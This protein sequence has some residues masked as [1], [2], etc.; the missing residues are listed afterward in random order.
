MR[1]LRRK[2]T[3][4]M[5]SMKQLILTMKTTTI[6]TIPSPPSNKAW[7]NYPSKKNNISSP[8]RPSPTFYPRPPSEW[9]DCWV[10]PTRGSCMGC[11]RNGGHGRIR[12]LVWIMLRKIPKRQRMR[13]WRMSNNCRHIKQVDFLQQRLRIVVPNGR[14][15]G[16]LRILNGVPVIRSGCWQVTIML[17]SIIH[18]PPPTQQE[19]WQQEI[20]HPTNN[21]L[22]HSPPPLPPPPH[23]HTITKES[24]QS[25]I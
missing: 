1:K 11:S 13:M 14:M 3:T 25:T 9:N 21:S 6:L 5:T 22:L 12:I 7:S 4:A 19:Q 2:R 10:H 18:L 20:C 8:R 17:Y 23:S 24:L 16:M 15:G